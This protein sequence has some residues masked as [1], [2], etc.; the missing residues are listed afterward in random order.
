MTVAHWFY[1]WLDRH[2]DRFPRGDWPGADEKPE[3]YRG[4]LGNFVMRGV[5]EDVAD[6]AS[7]R[8][9]GEPPE[10]V[11]QHIPALLAM[12]AIIFRERAEANRDHPAD[13]REAALLASRD[14]DDCLGM[15]L[16]LRYRRLSRGE[17]DARGMPKPDH[18]TCYCLCPMGRWVEKSHREGDEASRDIRKRIYD[19]REHPWLHGHEYRRP[20]VDP[21]PEPV[22]P[23][24]VSGRKDR[25]PGIAAAPNV[26]GPVEREEPAF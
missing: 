20:V 2:F 25:M 15:G 16:T 7:E 21:L 9:M 12:A 24:P 23:K 17:C 26:Y 6:E 8:L 5:T 22:V 4:W 13:S 18:I 10:F 11:G 3:F 14:C 1:V 19:L